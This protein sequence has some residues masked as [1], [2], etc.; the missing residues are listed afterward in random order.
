MTQSFVEN[1]ADYTFGCPEG[2]WT[3]HLDNKSWGKGKVGNLILYF[4]D[5]EQVLVF[6]VLSTET[7]A[8]APMTKD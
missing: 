1:L 8:I 3:A 5:V 4:S 2:K 7:T 6:G